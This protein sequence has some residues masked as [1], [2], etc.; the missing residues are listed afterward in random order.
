LA[1][2]RTPYMALKIVVHF[3]VPA[4]IVL[5]LPEPIRLRV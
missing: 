5:P 3:S 2:A 1:H 4:E